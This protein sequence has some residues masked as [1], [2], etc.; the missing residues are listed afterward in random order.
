MVTNGPLSVTP[1]P[2][3]GDWAPAF[4]PAVGETISK[5]ADAIPK[6]FTDGFTKLT[7]SFPFNGKPFGQ[8]DGV[9]DLGSA[10][11]A[12]PPAEAFPQPPGPV[13][14]GGLLPI[15]PPQFPIMSP[16]FPPIIPEIP[17]A[18]DGVQRSEP[19]QPP[20]D[21][22]AAQAPVAEPAP[23]PAPDRA[24]EQQAHEKAHEIAHA[25][26]HEIA[27]EPSAH[28]KAP[29]QAPAPAAPSA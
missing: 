2:A 1:F 7:G 4:P 14:D 25:I 18:G 8:V 6:V 11:P 16:R 17:R 15:I 26:A 13:P 10:L 19:A 28:D 5:A 24:Q 20:Q 29:E 27:H 12:L 23:G 9:G 22:A 21:P 3:F